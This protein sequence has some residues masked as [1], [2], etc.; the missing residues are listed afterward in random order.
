MISFQITYIHGQY[1]EEIGQTIETVHN[2]DIHKLMKD[3][4]YILGSE[5]SYRV[6][7]F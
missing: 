5:L 7:T 4:G 3:N 1:V 6:F 2:S